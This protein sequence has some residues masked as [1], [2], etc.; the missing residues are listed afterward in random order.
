M[1]LFASNHFMD[2]AQIEQS[3]G[4]GILVMSMLSPIGV[5]MLL[6]A[7]SNL[8]EEHSRISICKRDGCHDFEHP[9][10]WSTNQPHEQRGKP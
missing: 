4:G 6:L 1:S 9:A 5:V 7:L 8:T 10:P 2:A 3:L